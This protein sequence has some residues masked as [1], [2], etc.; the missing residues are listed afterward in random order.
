MIKSSLHV[1]FEFFGF[2][3][4][5]IEKEDF[6]AFGSDFVLFNRLSIMPWLNLFDFLARNHPE[7][8][9]LKGFG[10]PTWSARSTPSHPPPPDPP[11]PLN[12]PNL[13]S[14]QHCCALLVKLRNERKTH[15]KKR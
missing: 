4:P 12:T 14:L 11:P 2:V 1:K 13:Q 3:E 6:L 5:F 10:D 15:V 9:F 7:F 8:E